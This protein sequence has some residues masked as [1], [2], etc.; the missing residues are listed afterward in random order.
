[1]PNTLTSIAL[2]LVGGNVLYCEMKETSVGK[3]LNTEEQ[4]IEV[5]HQGVAVRVNKVNILIARERIHH[6]A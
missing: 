2:Q 6:V 4:F 3:L 1:M 5:F